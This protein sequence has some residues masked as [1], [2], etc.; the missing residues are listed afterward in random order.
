MSSGPEHTPQGDITTLLAA[1]SAG[2]RTAFD[3]LLP[4]VYGELR[5]LARRRGARVPGAAL[6][7]TEIVHE[8]YLKLS[9]SRSVSCVDRRHFFAVAARAMRQIAV[10]AARESLAGKRGGAAVHV[11]IDDVAVGSSSPV[12]AAELL[13]L[14]RAIDRLCDVDPRLALLVELRYFAGLSVE[15]AAEAFDTSTR[16]IKREWRKARALLFEDLQ[17]RG[18]PPGED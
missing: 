9:A 2:D 4:L 15:E 11:P 14:D 12:S 1:V 6:D 3:Q 8:T 16:T 7:T 18:E 10:D 17:R 5:A 13:D